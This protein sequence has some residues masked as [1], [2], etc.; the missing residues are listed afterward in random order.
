M[1]DYRDRLRAK[2]IM[3]AEIVRTVK[4]PNDLVLTSW[5]KPAVPARDMKEAA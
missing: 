4:Q 2:G 1:A 3:P 5:A